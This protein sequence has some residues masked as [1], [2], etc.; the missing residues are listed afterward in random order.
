MGFIIGLDITM[1]GITI[2]WHGFIEES[3]KLFLSGLG[4]VLFGDAILV[5]YDYI[6]RGKDGRRK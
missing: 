6:Y 4:V 5:V 3:F 2:M 1:F